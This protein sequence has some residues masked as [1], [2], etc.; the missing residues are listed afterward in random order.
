MSVP[1]GP[2]PEWGSDV[3][4]E[5][6]RRLGVA[7][8][9]VMP[10]ASFRGIHDSLVNYAGG[11]P[12]I[13]LAPHEE[14]AVDIAHGY[15][16]LTERPMAVA[17]HSNVGLLHAAMAIFDAWADRVPMLILGGT[18]P[19][20]QTRRRE[21]DWTHTSHGQGGVV[22]DFTKWEDEPGSLAAIPGVLIQGWHAASSAPRGPVYVCIDAALQETRVPERYEVPDVA[23]Y[24]L[25]APLAAPADAITLAA[26]RLASA[27][28]PVILPGSIGMDEATWSKLVGLAEAVGAAV[29]TG[30]W[31]TQAAFPSAHPQHVRDLRSVLAEAD[32]VLALERLDLA[33]TLRSAPAA[34]PREV[35]NVSTEPLALRS[36]AGDSHELPPADVSIVAE[37]RAVIPALRRAIEERIRG[38]AAALGRA[39]ERSRALAERHRSED[40]AWERRRAEL[41]DLRPISLVR[42]MGELRDALGERR[43]VLARMPIAWP[44]ETW[45]FDRPSSYLGADGGGSVGSGP[46]MSVGTALAAKER[47]EVAVAVLGDGDLLMATSAL[48]VAANQRLPLLVIVANN[49]T[50]LNDEEHQEAV[51]RTRGRPVENRSVGQRM[52]DPPVDYA[53]IAAGLGLASSGPLSAPDELRRALSDAMRALDEGRPYLIDVRVGVMR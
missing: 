13:V 9:S 22:R 51:A 4:V 5:M 33:G 39:Q 3:V 27:N 44:M 34:G 11:G 37:P 6:L 21:I 29:A 43:T 38:D 47:G 41:W 24:P 26:E 48:W 17:L 52:D 35:I 42:V 10:G 7:H 36:W 49:Q 45:V 16:K 28:R 15:T 19:L 32:V 20:D 12:H 2:R 50:Y 14:I 1:V 40:A 46:G 18:G 8:V 23:R 30:N 25:P 31:K 53:R